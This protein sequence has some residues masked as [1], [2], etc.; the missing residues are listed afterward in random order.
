MTVQYPGASPDTMAVSVA[1]PLERQFATIAG[2]TAITSLSTQGNTQIALEFDLNRNID[3]A[4]LDVQS[5]ISVAAARLPVDLPAPPAYRKVNPADAPIIF[6]ALTSDTAQS[7][8]MNEFADK[9]MSPRISTLPGVAQ[10]NIQGAQKRAVRIKYDLDALATR[11]ISVEEIRLAVAAQSS[12]APIG[13]IRTQQQ[14]YILEIK[15]AEPTAAYFKPL[16]VAWRNGAPVRLQD[17][18]KVEDSVENDE[19]RAEFNGVRSIIVSVQRQPDAN[20]VAVTDAINQTLTEFRT[21]LPPTIKLSVLSDRSESIR[22]A[23]HDVQLTLV[24]TA[25]LVILVI[26]AFLRTWRA[27]FIP[28]IALPLSIIGTFAG[29]AM[30]G[31]SL[32]NVSL[33]ALTLALGFVVDDAIVVLENIVRYVEQGMKPFDAAIR[34]ATEIGFTV[35]SITALAGGRVHPHPVHGRHRRALLLRIRHDHQHRHPAVGLHLADADADAGLA[36]AQAPHRRGE[37]RHPLARL[38]E[39]LRRDGHG[40]S[41]HAR[42]VAE[43][44]LA[45][46]AGDAGHGGGHG[47]MPLAPSRRASCRPRTPASSSCARKPPPTSPSRPCSTASASSPSASA[48]I[49]TCCTSTPT[50]SRPSSI[51]RSTAARSSCS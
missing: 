1:A 41:R 39:G 6:L 19:A 7:Q 43:G 18:A 25:V 40:L 51:P 35:L 37:A 32:D 17:I 49:P 21:L 34:G 30:L 50:C 45:D 46:A 47:V 12:V 15:G 31:F 33:L 10:V 26:L 28:A 4:A 11:G 3:A 23:V 48:P 13:S 38:R 5:S 29:M 24:L 14:L 16:V 36:H 42:L 8:E 22:D 2:I 44:A 20:T 9:V 27:T